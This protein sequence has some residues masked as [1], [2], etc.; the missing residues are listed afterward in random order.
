MSVCLHRVKM[1]GP[2]KTNRMVSCVSVHRTTRACCV[3][4]ML[5]NVLQSCL[6]GTIYPVTTLTAAISVIVFLVSDV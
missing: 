2:V 3:I 5:T 1:E 6:V 4:R